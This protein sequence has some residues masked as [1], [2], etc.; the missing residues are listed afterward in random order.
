MFATVRRRG[1]A[2]NEIFRLSI[3]ST[4]VESEVC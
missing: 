3:T 4:A 1:F 2:F